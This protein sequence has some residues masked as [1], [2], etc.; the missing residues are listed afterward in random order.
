M[1][2]AAAYVYL[3]ICIV[4]AAWCGSTR[5]GFWG[6]FV[7]AMLLSPPIAIIFCLVQDRTYRKR[8]KAAGGIS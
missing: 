2:F 1:S 4:L 8:A 7:A 5:I 3:A 6:N